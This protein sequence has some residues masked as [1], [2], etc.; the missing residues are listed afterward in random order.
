[1][2]NN[3][4]LIFEE[5]GTGR[6]LHQETTNFTDY[7]KKLVYRKNRLQEYVYVAY[8]KIDSRMNFICTQI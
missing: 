2:I 8:L 4:T 3:P 6:I 7:K 5:I 1:M